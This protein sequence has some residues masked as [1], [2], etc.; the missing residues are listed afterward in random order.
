M[1]KFPIFLLSLTLPCNLCQ[2]ISPG[3]KWKSFEERQKAKENMQKKFN[4]ENMFFPFLRKALIQSKNCRIISQDSFLMSLIQ[5]SLPENKHMHCFKNFF[6]NYLQELMVK[7][8]ISQVELQQK[9]EDF[10]NNFNHFLKKLRK[11]IVNKDIDASFVQDHMRILFNFINN[12]FQDKQ[13]DYEFDSDIS[14]LKDAYETLEKKA[15][16]RKRAYE[17]EEKIMR[18]K[19]EE[20]KKEEDS[21]ED[22]QEKKTKEEKIAERKK[23]WEFSEEQIRKNEEIDYF[24]DAFFVD[25]RKEDMEVIEDMILHDKDRFIV[26]KFLHKSTKLQNNKDLENIIKNFLSPKV[27]NPHDSIAI[28]EKIYSSNTL[29]K[30][31]STPFF[32]PSFVEYANKFVQD[33]SAIS[34]LPRFINHCFGYF[35]TFFGEDKKKIAIKK[36][37]EKKFIEAKIFDYPMAIDREM[38]ALFNFL[39]QVTSNFKIILPPYNGEIIKMK[40]EDFLLPMDYMVDF[41]IFDKDDK[42]NNGFQNLFFHLSEKINKS[43]QSNNIFDEKVIDDMMLVDNTCENGLKYEN[44]FVSQ[45]QSNKNNFNKIMDSF[46]AMQLS[47]HHVIEKNSPYYQEH[48]NLD[49]METFLWN[50]WVEN[51]RYYNGG[52]FLNINNYFNEEEEE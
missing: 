18:E 24:N 21:L 32:I 2:N 37:I 4:E 8:L 5:Q 34:K 49:D 14:S 7:C 45:N 50:K 1:K 16:E 52:V 43:Y 31:K 51:L 19:K 42:G 15:M 46:R 48:D 17:E 20:K 6:P 10:I 33:L 38:K 27:L 11:I 35:D 44:Y 28:R 40:V 25:N 29:F 26:E 30:I 47:Y 13:E 41:I 3:H 12:F 22:P 36:N 23:S 39:K 9:K